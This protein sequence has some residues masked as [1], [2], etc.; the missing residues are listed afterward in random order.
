MSEALTES[1]LFLTDDAQMKETDEYGYEIRPLFQTKLID[2]RKLIYEYTWFN[3]NAASPKSQRYEEVDRATEFV[4]KERV[5]I[6]P[7]TLAWVHDFT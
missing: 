2:T 6:Y 4:T 3:P 7:D 5:A 1:E